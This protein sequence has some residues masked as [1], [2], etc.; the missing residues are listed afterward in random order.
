M[1][2]ILKMNN[3]TKKF[4]T[5]T[6]FENVSLEL[7][8][9][10]VLALVGE[11]GAGKSTLMNILSGTYP[12]GAFE[13]RIFIN[14][15]E[16]FFK[17]PSDS[18]NAG[19][20]MI[21]QE[22]SLN[23]DLTVAE[24]IFLGRL[25]QRVPGVVDWKKTY[26]QTQKYLEMVRLD[27]DPKEPVRNLSTSQQQLLS[28][29]KSLV[30]Y[31]KVLVL[32]E[33]TSALT[34]QDA[35]NLFSIIKELCSRGISCIYISH[36][37]EEVF[38]IA[39]RVMVLRDGNVISCYNRADLKVNRIVEDMVGRKIDDMYPKEKVPL[40]H[41]VLRVEN[42]TVK[43]PFM[44]DKNIVENIGFS[45]RQGEI[46]GIAGLVGAGRTEI[47]NAIFGTLRTTD[48]EIYLNGEKMNITSPL[49][50][51]E[52]G[53]GL[54]T[55]DRKKTG[56]IPPMNL[57]ENM[58]ISSLHAVSTAGIVSK[59]SEQTIAQRFFDKLHVKAEGLNTNI[60]NLSGGNQQKIVLAK[61]LMKDLKVLILD[62]PTRGVDVGAKVEIYNIMN[63]LVKS[64]VAIIMISSDLP[65]L[66]GMCDRFLVLFGGKVWAEIPRNQVSQEK[67]MR[68]A[69]G[70]EEYFS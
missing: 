13:G 22:I 35:A 53:I 66:L 14:G 27:V 8:K 39:N 68:A 59:V 54:V 17:N 23:L 26:A 36:H 46:L 19:I 51:I 50:A 2:I 61:W 70:L 9:G 38:E 49:Q 69:T 40:G 41:E 18:Q 15:E 43:H 57:K 32:D 67:I 62:E 47:A 34:E 3:I 16:K 12:D 25:P 5:V 29:A 52:N 30:R 65:E 60:M 48:G 20:E 56:I 10:E 33:P 21:H 11:N 7:Y 31:P 45:L 6:V 64:K 1:E 55:E 37:L 24:N 44:A 58:T 4:G 28:I 63:E 42:F